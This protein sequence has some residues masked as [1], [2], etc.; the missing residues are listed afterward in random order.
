M[1]PHARFRRMGWIAVLALLIGLT[2][3]LHFKVHA[4]HS[5]VVRAERRIVALE[6]E[7][8]LLQTEFETRASQQQLAAWNRVDFGYTAP[9]ADQFLEGEHQLAALGPMM[10]PGFSNPVQFAGTETEGARHAAPV[11]DNAK[12]VLVAGPAPAAAPAR[13]KPARADSATG[14]KPEPQ[15][16]VRLAS[17]TI[18]PSGRVSLVALAGLPPE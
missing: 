8:L 9:T 17:A 5:D 2:V 3:A 10:L 13:T 11:A 16:D 1:T 12:P 15:R 7:K 4:V 6:Q 14:A 18:A